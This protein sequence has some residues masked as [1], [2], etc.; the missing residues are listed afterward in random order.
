MGGK[1]N[2][3]KIRWITYLSATSVYG[4]HKGEW[5]DEKSKTTP[6]SVNGIARLKVEKFWEELAQKNNLPLQIFRL[7]GIYSN[8]Y[9]VLEKLK[10]GKAKIINK[11]NHFF[12]RIHVE[13]IATALFKS[14][15]HFKKGEIYGIWINRISDSSLGVI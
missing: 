3:K 6:T 10:T 9:N 2:D 12:S 5:V 13:D 1:F 7:S 11:K 14:L 15:N 4:D 8:E